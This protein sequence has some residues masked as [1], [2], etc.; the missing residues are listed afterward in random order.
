MEI[1]S[2]KISPKAM[3]SM[4]VNSDQGLSLNQDDEDYAAKIQPQLKNLQAGLSFQGANANTE[5]MRAI[6]DQKIKQDQ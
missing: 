5:M 4:L 2:Q 6:N 1:S 3:S